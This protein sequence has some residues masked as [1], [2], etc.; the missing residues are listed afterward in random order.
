MHRAALGFVFVFALLLGGHSLPA[1]GADASKP[2]EHRGVLK[3]YPNEP[4][5]V[6]LTAAEKTKLFSGKPVFKTQEGEKGGRGVAFFHVNA[7][8]D[9]VW[10]VLSDFPS[11]PKWIGSM[12]EC[13]VYKTDG[14]DIYVRMK[15]GA[16]G[17]AVEY[18]IKHHYPTEKGYGTWTLDYD[19]KSDLDDSVGYWRVMPLPSDP[20]KSRVEY[21]VDLK[22]S[23]WVPGFIRKLLVNDGLKEATTWVRVQSEKR[24]AKKL[25]SPRQ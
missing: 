22:V 20:Q 8:Q 13:E 7:P 24:V 14:K 23:G 12:K 15:I 18:F 16:M 11:Y 5:K 4:P 21:S 6:P 9:V 10:S 3:N 2:H 17:M 25:P 19:R 1:H